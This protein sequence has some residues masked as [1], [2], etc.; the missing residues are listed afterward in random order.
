MNV[1]PRWATAE[2]P[3]GHR[4][5]SPASSPAKERRVP[6]PLLLLDVVAHPFY[7]QPQSSCL[8]PLQAA[9]FPVESVT[10][11]NLDGGGCSCKE[12]VFLSSPCF[13]FAGWGWGAGLLMFGFA[14]YDTEMVQTGLP[15]H[16]RTEK[17]A[18]W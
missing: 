6:G 13:L 16:I 17:S 15:C 8:S 7:P 5:I 4:W 10:F 14:N 18:P 2:R 3:R 9:A 11:C 1:C 12:M